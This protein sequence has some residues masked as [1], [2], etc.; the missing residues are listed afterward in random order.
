[1]YACTPVPIPQAAVRGTSPSQDWFLRW[2]SSA[3]KKQGEET[4]REKDV[5]DYLLISFSFTYKVQQQET[6]L[7]LAAA[8]IC[9]PFHSTCFSEL[10]IS[11]CQKS[12]V[13]ILIIKGEMEKNTQ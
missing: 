4:W 9:V 10:Y 12:G 6:S 3:L 5:K 13:E 11:A 1:M 2:V 7:D 8:G